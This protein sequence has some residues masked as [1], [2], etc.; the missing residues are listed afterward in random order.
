MTFYRSV[1][2]V[3]RKRHTVVRDR[4]DRLHEELIGNA[5]FADSSSLLYHRRSPSAVVS[6]DAVDEHR[7]ALSANHPVTPM[8]LQTTKLASD[9]GADLVRGRHVLGGND[10]LVLAMASSSDGG[11]L[12][13]NVVGDE[14]VYIADGEAVLASVFGELT[15]R[16]GDY[17]VVR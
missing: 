8:H 12:Y 6:I 7:P 5:G 4:G 10:D 14:L 1:G 3:P 13:R 11:P 17:V 2:V 16:E 15:V 9:A